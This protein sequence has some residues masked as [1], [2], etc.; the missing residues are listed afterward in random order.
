MSVPRPRP[1][2]LDITA[3]VGGESDAPGVGQTIKLS[4]NES[5]LGPS[6]G[7]LA[8]YRAAADGLHRYPDGA[9]A[10]LRRAIGQRWELDPARIVCGNGS[11]EILALLIRSYAGPGDE[12]LYSEYGFLMYRI[13]ALAA[14]A[15]PIA[16]P[17]TNYRGDIDAILG[18]VTPRTRLV[19]LANPNNPTGTFLPRQEMQRL[20]ASLPGD[21]VLVIDAAYAEFV[22]E[23]DYDAGVE[24]VE[25][26]DNVVMTRTFSKLYGLAALRVGWCFGPLAIV[27]VLNRVRGPFNITAPAQAAA[28]AALEDLAHEDAARRHNDHWRVWLADEL[29]GLGLFVV[30]S[31]TNFVLARFDEGATSAAR[32]GQFLKERG[33]L[34]RAMDGYCLGDCLRISV[35]LEAENHAVVGALADFLAAGRKHA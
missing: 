1:G 5:A 11:D 35:G 10:G 16:A 29:A 27:D 34:V 7:A 25:A 32:A 26:N 22:D 13:S 20:R 8:A 31:V 21:A 4:S 28:A 18:N 6:A 12:V 2:I 19:M 14:G 23:A 15:T 17:E 33:I 24:L 30:P 3:Y 9:S